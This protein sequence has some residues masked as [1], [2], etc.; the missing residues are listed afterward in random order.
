[1]RC[2][3]DDSYEHAADAHEYDTYDLVVVRV[4]NGALA[5]SRPCSHCVDTMRGWIRYVYYSDANGEIVREDV[6][7]MVSTHRSARHRSL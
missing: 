2:W 1:M 4:K 6:A 3:V 7:T 5:S